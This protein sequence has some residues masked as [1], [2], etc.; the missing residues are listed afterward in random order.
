MVVVKQ[1]QV[2]SDIIIVGAGMA[3]S[4]AAWVLSC[5]GFSVTLIDRHSECPPCFRAE[6]IEADQAELLKKLNLLDARRPFAEPIGSIIEVKAG[7][8]SA[9]DTVEQYGIRYHETVNEI[10]KRAAAN[11]DFR[12]GRVTGIQADRNRPAVFLQNDEM[13]NARLV[14]LACG[15]RAALLLRHGTRF[16]Y[17]DRLSSCSFGFDIER[18][19]GKPFEFRGLNYFQDVS[20]SQLDYIT[21]FRIGEVMR[22]NLFTQ[23]APSDMRVKQF[24][25]EPVAELKKMFPGIMRYAGE[26]AIKDKVEVFATQYYRNEIPIEPGLVYIGDA[27]QSV[28]PTTGTGLSK[29]LNDVDVLCNKCIPA[30]FKTIGIGERKLKTF[31][32]DKRK[33]IVDRNSRNV[34]EWYYR[35]ANG[36][37]GLLQIRK[38]ILSLFYRL[39]GFSSKRTD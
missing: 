39:S 13:L 28:S 16:E 8:L 35:R 3:G 14:I 21:L 31:Y 23:M 2:T 1:E 18:S 22:G 4:A 26:F 11:I 17:E 34:W 27:Y 19:D 5:Q 10:R 32:G 24:I 33:Q 7:Q 15:Y 30:W 9:T 38:R 6:K 20:Q 12:V 36:Y 37:E 29:V 25:A